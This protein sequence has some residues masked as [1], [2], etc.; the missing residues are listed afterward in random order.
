MTNDE[1]K[2]YMKERL[3]MQDQILRDIKKEFI[4]IKEDLVNTKEDQAELR[5]SIK[6]IKWVIGIGFTSLT[7]IIAILELILKS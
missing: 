2:E 3:D 5:G 6:A 1:L 7:I 4:P